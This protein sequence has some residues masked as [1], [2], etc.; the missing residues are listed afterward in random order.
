MDGI[1]QALRGRYSYD[2]VPL[3]GIP[4]LH[5]LPSA[6]HALARGR[7][8]GLY[9]QAADNEAAILRRMGKPVPEDLSQVVVIAPDWNG[10]VA[11]HFGVSGA[12]KQAT[13]IVINADGTIQGRASGPGA[14]EHVLAL[15]A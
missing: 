2:E 4:D 8:A 7:L 11:S 3:I 1:A 15:L 14:A 9:K 6:F 12:D 13:A 10:Q 5:G